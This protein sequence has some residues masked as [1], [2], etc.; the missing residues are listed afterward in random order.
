MLQTLGD[1]KFQGRQVGLKSQPF[2]VWLEAKL[3]CHYKFSSGKPCRFLLMFLTS[4]TSLND[5]FL[6]PLS[7][8]FFIFS[9]SIDFPTNPQQDDPFQRIAYDYSRADWDGLCD[10]LRDVPWDGIFKLSAF[11]ATCDFCEWIQV[12]IDVYIPH[13]KYKVKPHSSP[14]FSAACAA[15]IVHR[16]H[17]SVF[18]SRINLLNL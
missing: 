5:L 11:A 13:L 16:N 10:H 7:I 9:V 4:F 6:F 17:F 8:T 1:R 2:S 14:W 3:L 15:A 18:T 12:R